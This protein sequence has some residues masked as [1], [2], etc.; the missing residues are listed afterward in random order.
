MAKIKG[1][2]VRNIL[3]GTAAADTI[4]GLGG[5]DDLKGL[6]GNDTLDGG[7]GADRMWGGKGND[8]Y[9]VDNVG[10]KAIELAGQGTDLV[11]SKVTFTL[12]VNVENLTLTGTAAVN[13]TGNALGNAIKGNAAANR[14][15]GG[16][17]N[18]T[19][20][21]SSGADRLDGG[22]GSDTIKGG[23]GDDKIAGGFGNDTMFGGTGADEFQFNY[24]GAA[25]ASLSLNA[26]H[27]MDFERVAGAGGDTIHFDALTVSIGAGSYNWIASE[28]GTDT[29]FSLRGAF[30]DVTTITVHNVIG[31]VFGDDYSFG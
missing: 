16:D 17:G 24:M 31:L 1:T 19:L 20:D 23:V 11:K 12:G 6:A 15:S 29:I 22:A 7:T 9:L 3:N 21:G 30:F 5:N 2:N 4:L 8:T 18:D 28:V 25:T 27:I 13:G 14:L 10:D 26:D